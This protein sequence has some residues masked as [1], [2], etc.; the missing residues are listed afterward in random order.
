MD[1]DNV[2][3]ACDGGWMLDAFDWVKV[4]GIV[5]WDSYPRE[6][7]GMKSRC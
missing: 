5:E 7:I 3:W 2:D 4:N 1:C 6:Y